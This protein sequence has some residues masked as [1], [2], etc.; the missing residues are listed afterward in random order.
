MPLAKPLTLR[1][2]TE[3][4]RMAKQTRV[5]R[6]LRAM[7]TTGTRRTSWPLTSSAR[8]AALIRPHLQ[9]GE[10]VLALGLGVIP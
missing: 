6:R 4:L 2:S 8:L 7:G 1:V 5:I 9:V 10:F 3:T